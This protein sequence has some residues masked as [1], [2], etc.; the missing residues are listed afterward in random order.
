MSVSPV[1]V[2]LFDFLSDA[3]EAAIDDDIEPLASLDIHDTVYRSMDKAKPDGV[4]I[5]DCISTFSPTNGTD[6]KEWDAEVQLVCYSRVK[7]ANL[8]ERQ[9]A[10]KRVFD[11]QSAVIDLIFADCSLGGRVC[12]VRVEPSPRSYDTI[13]G[14]AY[15]VAL[16]PL[17]V[18]PS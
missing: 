18:N 3:V 16:I 15:A 12:D 5:S 7:T 10:L 14:N 17:V 2:A 13:D 8:K 4:R 11:I 6:L 9:D 1:E